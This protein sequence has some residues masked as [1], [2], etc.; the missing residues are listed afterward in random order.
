[1]LTSVLSGIRNV[2]LYP[3]LEGQR[4]LITGLTTRQGVDVARGFAEAGCRLVV[5]VDGTS[6][7]EAE[8]SALLEVL[9]YTAVELRATQG[10]L[11]SAQEAVRFAQGAAQAYGGLDVV[12]N[13]IQLDA[14]TLAA[15]ATIEDIEGIVSDVLRTAC[16]IT[17]VAAN[18]M[19]LTWT[20]GLILNVVLSPAAQ[21]PTETALHR[22]VGGTL[23]TMTRVEASNSADKGIRINAIG[24]RGVDE[25]AGRTTCSNL[26]RE[27]DIAALALHLASKRGATLSGHLFDATGVATRRC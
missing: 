24:P 3:E 1:M 23:A 12:I 2:R 13:L 18:R 16:L 14:V 9:S 5:Q 15:D 21:S 11:G 19:S 22:F 6:E 27:P 20:E 25:S 17:K 7:T 8:S 4:V 10:T 26:S